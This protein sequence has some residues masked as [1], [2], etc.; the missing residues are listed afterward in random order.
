MEATERGKATVVAPKAADEAFLDRPGFVYFVETIDH[1]FIKIGFSASLRRRMENLKTIAPG[2]FAI[3]LIGYMVGSRRV[4]ASLHLKFSA[5]W[6]RGEW[7]HSTDELRA[8]ISTCQ[9]ERFDV[10]EKVTPGQMASRPC[11]LPRCRLPFIPKRPQDWKSEFCCKEHQKEFWLEANKIAAAAIAGNFTP[12]LPDSQL[13]FGVS[14]REQ[15]LA[16]L[17]RNVNQWVEHPRELL[18]GVVW[19]S[20]ISDL[21][22]QGYRI[23]T[24]V[25]GDR[26]VEMVGGYTRRRD[27]TFVPRSNWRKFLPGGKVEYQYMLVKLEEP[28]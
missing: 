21:R 23:E 10:N 13:R 8:F 25:V 16:I 17:E 4:E 24:R 18:P 5:N 12:A 3:Q 1:A 6:D 26:P 28:R 7:F 19:N 15:V 20:R 9:L 27:K 11:K 2:S 22:R 14:H